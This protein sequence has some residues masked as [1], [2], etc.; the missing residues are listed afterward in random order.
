M[1]D[2]KLLDDCEFA[3]T[4]SISRIKISDSILSRHKCR[5]RLLSNAIIFVIISLCFCL[6]LLTYI[7]QNTFG[8]H[9][10]PISN[11]NSDLMKNKE[12]INL[13]NWL[14]DEVQLNN[15][16]TY[17]QAEKESNI[18]AKYWLEWQN[19]SKNENLLK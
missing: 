4:K 9:H 16:E 10:L 1:E 12:N 17:W 13:T 6:Y 8:T 11:G 7:N 19:Y 5:F 18:A 15:S 3:P 2:Q 14:P